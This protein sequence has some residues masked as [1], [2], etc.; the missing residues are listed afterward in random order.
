MTQS[1]LDI[2][3]EG[4]FSDGVFAENGL[5]ITRYNCDDNSNCRRLSVY[6]MGPEPKPN[7][8]EFSRYS[9][10]LNHTKVAEHFEVPYEK[11]IGG[12]SFRLHDGVLS[13]SGGSDEVGNIPE[14]VV[15]D[16]AK[17]LQQYLI[18]ELNRHVVY[19]QTNSIPLVKPTDKNAGIWGKLGYQ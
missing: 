6:C 11:I 7:L 13:L 10:E 5:L 12:T 14:V 2:R 19:A 17:K 9:S 16:I 3:I 8:S 18:E 15:L 4:Y 1:G